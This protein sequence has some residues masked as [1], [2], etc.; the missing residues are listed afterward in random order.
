[1]TAIL[2]EEAREYS[3][4]TAWSISIKTPF[5]TAWYILYNNHIYECLITMVIYC[6]EAHSVWSMQGNVLVVK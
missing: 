2:V 5:T 1:M 6:V 3:K 4:K